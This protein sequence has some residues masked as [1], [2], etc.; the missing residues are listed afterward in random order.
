MGQKGHIMV[1]KGLKVHKKR[2][3]IEFLDLKR[4]FFFLSGIGGYP[5]PPLNGKSVWKKKV[6]FLNGQNPLKRKWKLPLSHLHRAF[7]QWSQSDRPRCQNHRAW[8]NQFCPPG[9][10]TASHLGGSLLTA[11]EDSARQT[12][13]RRK[14]AS[15]VHIRKTHSHYSPQIMIRLYKDLG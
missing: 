7:L 13:L 14:P 10:L 12:Q 6:F 1:Q 8:R 9:C 4:R 11:D 5:H 3:K 15:K 2:Q